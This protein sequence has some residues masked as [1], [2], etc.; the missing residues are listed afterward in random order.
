MAQ[1]PGP[2]PRRR[3]PYFRLL[4]GLALAGAAAFGV[5]A[6]VV[7]GA[8]SVAHVDPAIPQ[9]LHRHADAHPGWVRVFHVVTWFGTF[10]GVTPLTVAAVVLP[11]RAG[12]KRL[13]VAWLVTLIGSGLAVELFKDVFDRPRPVWEHP[14]AVEESFSFPS[15]HATCSAV[16][17][18][19]A[20]YCLGLRW[21]S[22]RRRL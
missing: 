22:W 2:H 10:R 15:G 13:A 8:E 12:Q 17:Y 16:G 9:A 5:L 19:L 1:A 18:G 4:A 6:A 11:A 21:R 14:L 20:A 7:A 3:S